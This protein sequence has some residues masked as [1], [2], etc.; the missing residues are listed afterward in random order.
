MTQVS[1][2]ISGIGEFSFKGDCW[3]CLSSTISGLSIIIDNPSIDV[4]IEVLTEFSSSH[5]DSVVNECISYIESRR[6]DYGL[7]AK[8]FENPSILVMDTVTVFFETELEA[9]A[10]VGVEFMGSKPRQLIIGD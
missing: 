10:T 1:H 9:E 3:E 7:L 4:G 6:S 2:Q 5:N 8:R